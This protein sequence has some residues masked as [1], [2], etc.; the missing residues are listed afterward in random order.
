M[1]GALIREN[2]EKRLTRRPLFGSRSFI[3]LF[4]EIFYS[5]AFGKHFEPSQREYTFK[6]LHVGTVNNLIFEPVPKVIKKKY[7]DRHG[8]SVK[9]TSFIEN[10]N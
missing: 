7:P 4:T 2:L 9:V 5:T 6:K 3:R 8:G 10:K 1:L